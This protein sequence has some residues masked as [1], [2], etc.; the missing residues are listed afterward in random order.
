[1]IEIR[2]LTRFDRAAIDYELRHLG[3]N[4]VFQ[5]YLR[6]DHRLALSEADRLKGVDHWHHE[7]LIAF[8]C[9]PRRPIG[10]VEYVRLKDFDT[11]ELAISVVDG[12]QRRGVGRQL[13]MELRDRARAAGIRRFRATIMRGNR[14]AMALARELGPVTSLGG[15]GSSMDWL[16]E[17]A[18]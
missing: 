10:L 2:E 17:L 5:R 7:G 4:S 3:E 13:T 1:M 16:V 8:S 18:G 11:A 15:E 14:G 12:W 9:C 6:L